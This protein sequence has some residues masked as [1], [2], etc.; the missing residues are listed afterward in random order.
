MAMKTS[1]AKGVSE[2]LRSAQN[3]ANHLGQETMAVGR[4][5]GDE[6]T[7]AA[8]NLAG[9]SLVMTL[10]LV[11]GGFALY[12]NRSEKNTKMNFDKLD[13]YGG[14]GV[15]MDENCN[16]LSTKGMLWWEGASP[17]YSDGKPMSSMEAVR[18]H[19]AH[20]QDTL[21]RLDFSTINGDKSF[22][23]VFCFSKQLVKNKVCFGINGKTP[24]RLELSNKILCVNDEYFAGIADDFEKIREFFQSKGITIQQ[25]VSTV[26]D[27]KGA[28]NINGTS[29]AYE[30]LFATLA[31]DKNKFAASLAPKA[32]EK[33]NE[34][35]D[36]M[37]KH[38]DGWKFQIAAPTDEAALKAFT[39]DIDSLK[40]ELGF[41]ESIQ[42]TKNI[43]KG[44]PVVFQTKNGLEDVMYVLMASTHLPDG[45]VKAKIRQWAE[46]KYLNPEHD[47]YFI[48]GEK[49]GA[50]GVERTLATRVVDKAQADETGY[51]VTAQPFRDIVAHQ[52]LAERNASNYERQANAMEELAKQMSREETVKTA[53]DIT[54]SET[55]RKAVFE[56]TNAVMQAHPGLEFA[57]AEA[58]AISRVKAQMEQTAQAVQQA[59]TTMF[60]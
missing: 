19:I 42:I 41:F 5:L 2:L 60:I 55:F 49:Q 4:S 58:V 28:F 43:T 57:D 27:R 53:V 26:A 21:Q 6:D 37:R 8:L 13:I 17:I 23:D 35:L 18:K 38:A 40:K 15:P 14:L 1:F 33:F 36:A 12:A 48:Y 50:S 39:R 16:V 10:G 45:E 25:S 3:T 44:S 32:Q 22:W 56:E 29:E 24:P 34:I 47:A 31:D 11:G 59:G 30:K 51:E 20:N 9:I 46:S 52:T 7:G 54:T